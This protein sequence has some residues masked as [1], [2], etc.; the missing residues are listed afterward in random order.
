MRTSLRS[1]PAV[2][3]LAA[4]LSL[5][6][7]APASAYDTGPHTEITRDA[8]TTEGF[9]LDAVGV[10]QVNNWFVDFYEQAGKNPFTGHGGFWKR[11]LAGAIQTEGWADDVIA[12]ADRTHFDS[13]TSILFNSVGVTHEWDRLR[14]SVWTLVNEA[15]DENDPAKLLT[16]LG[17]SLHQVQD[18]YTHTNWVEPETGLGAEGPG[19]KDRGFGSSPTWFDVP[20]D[21]RDA[22]TIYTANT[23]GHTRQHGNWNTDGNTSLNT[24]M[25]KDWPGRPLYLPSATT[26][27][28]ASRQWIEA[29][30]SWVGNDAFWR[31]A[32]GYRAKQSQLDHD[33]GG[34][35]KISLYGG[36]WQGQGEPLGGE[37]GPG[38]SLIDLRQAIKGYFQKSFNLTG[39]LRG[40]TEYRARFE[41]LI[42]RIAEPSPTGQLGPVPS[43]QGIQRNTK[44]VVLRIHR[45]RSNGLVGGFGDPGPDRADMYANVRI[46]GQPMTSAVIEGHDSFS[47]G[48]PNEPYTWIKAVPAVPNEGVPVEHIEVEVKTSN[49]GSSGTDDDV[50]LRVGPNLRFPLDKRLYDDFERGDRD[51]YS[52]P[53]D[54]ATRAGMT[55][56]DIRQVGIEKSRDG[57]A[58][59]WKLGGVKLIVNGRL[60]YSNQGIN[61]WLEDSHRTW[62]APN[63]TRRATRG[64]KIPVRLRLDEDDYLYGGDDEGD[65]NPFDRRWVVLVGYIPDEN[66]PLRRTTG[67]GGR[68]GGRLDDG[69]E[70]TI[71]YSIETIEPDLIEP[72]VV[73]PPPPP[74]PGPKPDLI[75]TEFF[76]SSVTVKNQGLGAAG[77][78]RL[79]M[80][81]STSVAYQ[82]F[83]GLAAGASETRTLSDLSFCSTTWIATVDDIGQVEETNETN[84]TRNEDAIVC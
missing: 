13:S 62:T 83:T 77:P 59:G 20:A 69:D 57:I 47:F 60:V 32:Q 63:F 67:G 22:V 41:R 54:E 10:A 39:G 7:A 61:R 44:I 27:Y 5:A 25:N 74:P 51:T 81:N 42:K 17:V 50:Y 56:G 6:A 3:V 64:R 49:S 71:T 12:A 8:M 11:L 55:V 16:V 40:R 68:L 45:M 34:A 70:A 58:G 29:V 48:N 33:L 79:R 75:V 84:N 35:Y 28:F 52:V 1:L 73:P 43:S 30:R 24:A 80:D 9:R 14:R 82:S 31:R 21:K 65:I 38:G 2:A 36:H 4:A 18:F 26:A 78:F 15:R 53:I 46:D 23:Q 76:P 72:V 37:H 19:W 66:F